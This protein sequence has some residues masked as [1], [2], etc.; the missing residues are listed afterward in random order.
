MLYTLRELECKDVVS[1]CDGK[2]L[3]HISDLEIDGDCGKITAIY[4]AASGSFWTTNRE[5]T[6][7]PW[8]HVKCFGEDTV[9]VDYRRENNC[10]CRKGRRNGWF[11]LHEM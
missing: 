9:L 8:D 1:V 3:G 10:S 7:I 4:I 6:R 5:E 11:N 2:Y